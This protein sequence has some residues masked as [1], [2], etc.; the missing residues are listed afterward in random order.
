MF[1][2]CSGFC[3]ALRTTVHALL[4]FCLHFELHGTFPVTWCPTVLLAA[5][6]AM[7]WENNLK[8]EC[9]GCTQEWRGGVG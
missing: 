1:G 6:A 8:T 7:R 3:T 2:S 9:V 5:L 4:S